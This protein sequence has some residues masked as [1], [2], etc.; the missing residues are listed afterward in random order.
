MKHDEVVERL[1]EQEVG[2]AVWNCTHILDQKVVRAKVSRYLTNLRPGDSLSTGLWAAPEE[3]MGAMILAM[4]RP[5][6]VGP[7]SRTLLTDESVRIRYKAMRRA[8]GDGRWLSA[9]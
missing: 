1:C 3:P 6:G 2:P 7:G 8:A 4:Q 9:P 5:P